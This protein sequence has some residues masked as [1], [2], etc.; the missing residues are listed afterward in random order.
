MKEIKSEFLVPCFGI[1]AVTWHF[2]MPGNIVKLLMDA[3]MIL[4]WSFDV[5]S[6]DFEVRKKADA[7]VP[8]TVSIS[9]FL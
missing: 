8:E 6:F 3:L 4:A 9:L 1:N 5:N 7:R 2:L